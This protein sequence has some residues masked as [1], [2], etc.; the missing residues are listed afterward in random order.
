MALK[1][2]TAEYVI[3]LKNISKIFPGVKALEKVNFDLC[4]SEVHALIGENGAGKST[5]IKIIAGFYPPD[6][7]SIFMNGQEVKFRSPI[8]SNTKG[9]KV[10]YQELNLVPELSI[11]ENV[12]LGDFPTNRFGNINWKIMREKTKGILSQLGLEVDP[13]I[14]VGG[15][16]VAEQ[17]IVEIA[18]SISSGAK[19]LIMDEPTSALSPLECKNLF[20][21]INN[22]KNHG[23][24]IIYVTH[25]LQEIYKVADRVTVLRDG[26]H[27]V[28]KDVKDSNIEELIHYMVGRDL[29]DLFPKT[30]RKPKDVLLSVRKVYSSDIKNISFDLCSGE[31]LGVFGLL[32]SGKEILARVLYGID[33]VMNGEIYING[34][35][36]RNNSP[37]IARCSGVGL[38]TENRREEGI[39]PLLS[40]KRNMT[41]PSLNTLSNRGWLF[42]PRERQIAKAYVK[43]LDIKTPSLS[44][45]V[46][47]LSGGNQQKVI[48]ARWM[49]H[50]LKVLIVSEPTRGIDVGSKAEI[51]K[52]IDEMANQGM[53][54]MMI[55]SEIEEIMGLSDRIIVMYEG[56]IMKEFT[57]EEVTNKKLMTAAVGGVK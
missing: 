40:V 14:K 7:G 36:I 21:L 24:S 38:I 51:H 19:I 55:S 28:T 11:A 8:D 10:V 17:Q 27:I 20:D 44:R 32:G 53:A 46:M 49:I 12:F 29:T 57:R 1:T 18:R 48:L 3:E 31:V 54:I 45:E 6:E 16:R 56:M 4:S 37:Y 47:Y 41:L 30:I 52:I 15:L 43:R 23:V 34:K 5:M 26:K 9:I 2:N 33:P 42:N 13:T 39:I 25:K 50:K 35:K 22:L